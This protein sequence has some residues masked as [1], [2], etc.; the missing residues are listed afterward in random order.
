MHD[1][2]D[3]QFTSMRDAL[4]DYTQSEHQEL[5]RHYSFVAL[6]NGRLSLED[7][8]DLVKRLYGFYAPL[9]EAIVATLSKTTSFAS[10]VYVARAELLGRDL[11]DLGLSEADIASAPICDAARDLVTSSNVGGVIYVIEGATLGGSF[12][13]RASIKLLSADSPDGR[14]YWNWCSNVKNERWA[15]A[16]EYLDHLDISGL[17]L[18][19]LRE[20]ARSTFRLFAD[21]IAP[22]DKS[23][24]ATERRGN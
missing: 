1:E 16:T 7:Y 11:L 22:L 6:F 14:N 2:I 5:H 18:H 8:R 4:K 9:D 19:G 10:Y 23:A 15:M 24:R 17:G 20:G 13:N 12:I 21:W 3:G